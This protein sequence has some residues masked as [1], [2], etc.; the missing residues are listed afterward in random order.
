MSGQP[1]IKTSVT[2]RM[3]MIHLI[4][5]VVAVVGFGIINIISGT[6]L[7]GILIMAFGIAACA[8]VRLFRTGKVMC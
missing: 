3:V 2:D 7:L 8:A 5:V 1:N 4:V 6:V